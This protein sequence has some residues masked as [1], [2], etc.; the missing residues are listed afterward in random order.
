MELVKFCF[1]T[2]HSSVFQKLESWLK[3]LNT[4]LSQRYPQQE[5]LPLGLVAL[6]VC[7]FS[8]ISR[9]G[10]ASAGGCCSVSAF[11]GSS[12]DGSVIYGVEI[13]LLYCNDVYEYPRLFVIA[14]I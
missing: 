14:E 9:P 2:L 11:I 4:P 10:E 12:I 1:T 3:T 13:T 6:A 5:T 8:G 7:N